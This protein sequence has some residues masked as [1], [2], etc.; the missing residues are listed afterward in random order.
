MMLE[1]VYRCIDKE[2]VNVFFFCDY[3]YFC[4]DVDICCKLLFNLRLI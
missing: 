4:F 1:K 2:K 3:M